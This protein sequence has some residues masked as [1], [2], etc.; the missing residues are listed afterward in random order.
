[1]DAAGAP[2]VNA[3][4][5]AVL[6]PPNDTDVAAVEIFEPRPNETPGLVFAAP[7]GVTAAVG[8]APNEIAE[9]VAG[10]PK[11]LTVAW[12]DPN[13][14]LVAGA[15]DAAA[16]APLKINKYKNTVLSLSVILNIL[17]YS[18]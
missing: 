3:V 12:A 14:K 6:A 8:G 15:V 16:G 18:L 13:E 1:M 7:K 17:L 5:G 2:N 10:T 9:L 11:G 4:A